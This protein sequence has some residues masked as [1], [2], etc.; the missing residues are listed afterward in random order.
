VKKTLI[1]T[2]ALLTFVSIAPYGLVHSS[3]ASKTLVA[4]GIPNKPIIIAD[5][6]PNKPIVLADGIPNKP[7]VLADG[8]PNKPIV[9]S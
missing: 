9:N 5:G 6:I 8:I 1:A 7:I 4:D 2:G 3:I